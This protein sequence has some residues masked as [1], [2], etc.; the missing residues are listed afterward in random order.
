MRILLLT[1]FLTTSLSLFSQEKPFTYEDYKQKGAPEHLILPEGYTSIADSSFFGE[2]IISVSIPNS[3][4][5]IG[6]YAFYECR[7]LKQVINSKVVASIGKCAFGR[8][9]RLE[10]FTLS[11]KINAIEEYT[12]EWCYQLTT[13]K[14][15]EGVTAIGRNAFHFC[16]NLET[17]DFPSTLITIKESAFSFCEHL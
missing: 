1:L 7:Y 8:C 9:K 10:A 13:I 2:N 14:I 6:D 4:T 12:F 11:D 5:T 16:G 15:P 17:V 3:L